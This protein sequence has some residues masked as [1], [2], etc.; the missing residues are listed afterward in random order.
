MGGLLH[1]LGK[2]CMPLDI[3]N[4]PG[5]LTDDV[6]SVREFINR[7]PED[8]MAVWHEASHL[9]GILR[10]LGAMDLPTT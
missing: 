2:A 6:A 4:K 5:Q 9:T 7:S 10:R 1:D 8:F 3:L